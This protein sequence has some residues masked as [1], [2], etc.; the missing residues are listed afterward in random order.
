MQGY[1]RSVLFSPFFPANGFASFWKRLD[2]GREKMGTSIALP[3]LHVYISFSTYWT[4]NGILLRGSRKSLIKRDISFYFQL[5]LFIKFI[6]RRRCKWFFCDIEWT[7]NRQTLMLL[8]KIYMFRYLNIVYIY[9]FLIF[10][11]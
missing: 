1:F 10:K 3:T 4:R 8:I 5:F 9:E 6:T 7:V 2:K 11:K